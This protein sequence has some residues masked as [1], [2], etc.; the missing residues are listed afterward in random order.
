MQ[1]WRSTTEQRKPPEDAEFYY[2]DGTTGHSAIVCDV[3]HRTDLTSCPFVQYAPR[4]RFIAAVPIRTPEG[5]PIGSFTILDDKPRYG[6]SAVEM[7]FME[8]MADTVFAHLEM[9]RAVSQG[10]RGDR[11]IKGLSLFNEKKSSLR[12]WWL[13]SHSRRGRGEGHGR[14]ALLADDTKMQ[15]ER[16]DEELGMTYNATDVDTKR[17]SLQS[18]VNAAADRGNG[19]VDEHVEVSTTAEN[20]DKNKRKNER[21]SVPD[22]S[23][24]ISD[25]YA[26]ASN[27][28]REA[29]DA[30]GVVFVDAH[31]GSSTENRGR[32]GASSPGHQSTTDTDDH[33]DADFST[34]RGSDGERD[35][36]STTCFV[37][38]F[39]TKIKSSVR[40]F[41]SSAK[42]ATL[43]QRFVQ[44]LVQ[45]FPHGKVFSF[46]H[47][48]TSWSSSGGEGS[49]ENISSGSS[50]SEVS[51]SHKSRSKR[52]GTSAKIA[53]I[54]PEVQSVAFLPIWDSGRERW[55]GAS[56]AWSSSKARF[57]ETEEDLTYLKAFSDSVL[58][59]LS[60]L[61]IIASNNAKSTFIASISH[62]L[63]SP[64]HGVL[65]GAEFLQDSQL[66]MDQWEM[67]RTV[68]VAGNTLLDTINHI[69]DFTKINSFTDVQR[70]GR[71]DTDYRRSAAFK[72]ADMG[73][74]G[75]TK[76]F[77]LAVLSEN[78]VETVVKA[79]QFELLSR[80][81]YRNNDSR[82]SSGPTEIQDPVH[83][84]LDL[85]KL[86]SWQIHSS[87]G[88]WTRIINN[89]VGN[90]LKYTIAGSV[91]VRLTAKADVLENYHYIN[92]SIE[93]SG[94]GISAEYLQHHLYTPFMQENSHAVGT[95]L[96][97]S[98]V[99]Q[100]VD[101]LGGRIDVQSVVGR[102]TRILVQVKAHFLPSEG[103]DGL[104]VSGL[105][106]SDFSIGLV[107][108]QIDEEEGAREAV[109][110][111]QQEQLVRT[112]VRQTLT[113]WL[114]YQCEAMQTLE[115]IS[116]SRISIMVESD[117]AR[118]LTRSKQQQRG[119]STTIRPSMV[120]VLSTLALTTNVQRDPELGPTV[121]F[122]TQ[123]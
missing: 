5:K 19:D 27:L 104:A 8:D 43:S 114:E 9:K 103:R 22:I 96:G 118:L 111:D 84:L 30:D 73:E 39:S 98:I 13:D 69:L 18:D 63:R 28:I 49:L 86:P 102:G 50:P 44:R 59:E 34:R 58:A 48:G 88:S 16:A 11:L 47:D 113:Q 25:V 64:L 29:M 90:A 33:E 10:Q 89:L 100:I 80:P 31:L 79:H 93:D 17:R 91:V 26:R 109:A 7:V 36:E 53:E 51:A 87:P 115:N 116:V 108:S 112:N 95:G 32:L 94:Q 106:D 3:R 1:A 62:E 60:R 24:Q 99:K 107:E 82:N 52:R 81:G 41:S 15:N 101:E 66:N 119:G 4:L 20:D 23:T 67:A 21:G 76:V 37:L 57:L 78:V 35:T 46:A 85:E 42:Y 54:F 2:T 123:P 70:R 68:S 12:D 55:R 45:R 117:Y 38:G 65:A 97:L 40:G 72:T 110:R 14:R 77:D 105:A 6:L 75:V 122:I 71:L 92:L 61:D 74:V 56:F 83:V 120:M 121:V